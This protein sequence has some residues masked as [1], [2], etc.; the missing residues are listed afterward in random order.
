M[1]IDK[2][3]ENVCFLKNKYQT[4]D[5]FLICE[6]MGIA[7]ELQSMGEKQDS[8]KG[9]VTRMCG[10]DI[11]TINSDLIDRF[12]LFACAHE[13]GHIITNPKRK[14]LSY[15]DNN[16][17]DTTNEDEKEAN[18]FAAELLLNDDEVMEAVNEE[19]TY[20]KAASILRV[21][22]ELLDLKLRIMCDKGYKLIPPMIALGDC[23][24]NIE[25][26]YKDDFE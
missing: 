16:Y 9:F 13:L 6:A 4:N 23:F 3:V 12:Q 18:F 22:A 10:I 19:L 24:G 11:V 15:S 14:T 8:C 2:I 21:P 20:T 17:F 1:N 7:V 25:M 5:P 26:K